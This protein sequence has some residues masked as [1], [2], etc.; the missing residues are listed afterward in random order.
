[1]GEFPHNLPPEYLF[2]LRA[3]ERLDHERNITRRGNIVKRYY[4]VF[5]GRGGPSTLRSSARKSRA[6]PEEIAAALDVGP[7]TA[8]LIYAALHGGEE[9]KDEH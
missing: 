7:K 2:S 1:M 8:A 6:T 5:G 4:P 3:S 9:N